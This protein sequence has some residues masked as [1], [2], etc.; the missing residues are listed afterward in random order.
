MFDASLGGAGSK[1]GGSGPV[2][3]CASSSFRKRRPAGLWAGLSMPKVRGVG[4]EAVG[5]EL[6]ASLIDR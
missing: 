3:R 2:L 6:G 4:M 1:S 5:V